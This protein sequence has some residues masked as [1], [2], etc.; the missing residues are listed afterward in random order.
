MRSLSWADVSVILTVRDM[1]ATLPSQWQTMVHNGGKFSWP[2]YLAALPEP[3]VPVFTLPHLPGG[4]RINFHRNQNIPRMLQRWSSAIGDGSLHVVTVPRSGAEP[5][6]LWRRFADVLDVD[7][8]LATEPP[9]MTNPSLGYASSDLVRRLNAHLG[10]LPPSEYNWTVKEPVALRQ[11]APRAA[12]EERATVTRAAYDLAL[13]WNALTRSA[14]SEARASVSGDLDD[15]PV[16]PDDD[17]RAGLPSE[18]RPPSDRALLD[19]AAVAGQG[20]SRVMRRRSRQLKALG[21]APDTQRRPQVRRRR[22][23]W[24]AADDPVDA[25]SRD[26]ADQAK[27]AALLLRRLRAERRRSEG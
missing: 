24:R 26:L 4:R 19:A 27:E 10:R 3:G 9:P 12:V 6:L 25:A 18:P 21:V 23:Q 13:S 16:T 17:Y 5:D 8:S 14:V 1:A 2:D 15:L 22:R 7:P 20:L 11:L